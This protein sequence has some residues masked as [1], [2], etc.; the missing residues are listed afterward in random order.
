METPFSGLAGKERRKIIN[1][2][3]M[4]GT[5]RILENGASIAWL[6]PHAYK[7]FMLVAM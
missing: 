5:S 6:Q 2:P 1:F 3:L 4:P 7:P